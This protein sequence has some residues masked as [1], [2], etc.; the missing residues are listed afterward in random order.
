MKIF[1]DID[2]TICTTNNSTYINCQPK[3]DCIEKINKLYEQGHIIVYWSDRSSPRDVTHSL[4]KFTYDSLIQWGAKFHELRMGKPSFD[5]YI[6]DKTVNAKNSW[7]N[8]EVQ[9][10]L[11]H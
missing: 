3:V 4:F 10:I 1:V 7:D 6:S 11:Y 9:N 5:L 2:N 8:S